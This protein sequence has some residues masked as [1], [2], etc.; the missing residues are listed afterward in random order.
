MSDLMEGQARPAGAE[1]K[2]DQLIPYY[3]AKEKGSER[4]VEG[5]YFAYPETTYCF[6]EDYERHPVKII[7]CIVSHQMSDWGLPNEIVC[8]QIDADT[9]EQIGWFDCGRI[10]YGTEEWVHPKEYI[11]GKL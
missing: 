8:C 11:N 1:N 9:L 2:S 6:T 3:R 5:F 10:T 4:Y 7:H